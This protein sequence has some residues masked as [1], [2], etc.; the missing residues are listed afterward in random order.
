[1]KD[2]KP[3]IGVVVLYKCSLEK[4]GT[5]T[6]LNKSLTRIKKRL[7]LLVYDN[8]PKKQYS[9]ES[10]EFRKFDILYNHDPKNPGLSKAYNKGVN[11]AANSGADW[12]LLLDQDTEFSSEFFESYLNVVTQNLSDEIVCII[13]KVL[14][15]RNNTLFSPSK[16]YYGGITR[17]ATDIEP[18]IIERPITGI[19]SG[20][21]ISIQFIKSIGGFS[22][23]YPLDML[24]HWYFREI[25]RKKKKVLLLNACIHHN[26]SVDSFFEEVSITRYDS[27]LMSEKKFFRINILDL[28]IYKFRLVFRLVKQF[29]QGRIEYARLTLKYLGK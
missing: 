5:I 10:F 2:L 27:I 12:I 7:T 17:P 28:C 3:L 15:V 23:E 26:L 9:E 13:P 29:Q 21:L 25:N 16:I 22:D 4:S 6:S 14:S 18:G 19:N 1:M 11:Y 24:D 8:G 20:T